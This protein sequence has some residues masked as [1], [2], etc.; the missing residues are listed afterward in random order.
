MKYSAGRGY[1]MSK[2][3][4]IMAIVLASSFLTCAAVK[5]RANLK[6]VDLSSNLKTQKKFVIGSGDGNIQSRTNLKKNLETQDLLCTDSDS[7]DSTYDCDKILY[8]TLGTISVGLV[9]LGF[10]AAHYGEKAWEERTIAQDLEYRL[11]RANYYV[12][13]YMK[14]NPS[15]DTFNKRIWEVLLSDVK[16]KNLFD[17]EKQ[18]YLRVYDFEEVERMANTLD[19]HLM[20]GLLYGKKWRPNIDG[21]EKL[22]RDK[23]V[24]P[25]EDKRY[26]SAKKGCV[27]W[28]P[29]RE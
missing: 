26:D 14:A 16:S 18:A 12:K 15:N 8:I 22:L 3:S 23:A 1:D 21:V 24:L 10:V 5:S 2:I 6:R 25:V 20:I 29:P 11:R 4:S 17:E 13:K 19:S 28:W 9:I 7:Y 27:T